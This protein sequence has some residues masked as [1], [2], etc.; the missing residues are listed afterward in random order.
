V[1]AHTVIE[2]RIDIAI[3]DC[4]HTT[5]GSTISTVRAPAR[6]KFLTTKAHRAIAALAG[7][8]F[9]ARF[10]EEL[11]VAM[12]LTANSKQKTPPARQGF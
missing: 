12:V 4:N 1:Y 2:E 5:A 7:M 6:H 10:V 9:N 3:G 8:N 11:H